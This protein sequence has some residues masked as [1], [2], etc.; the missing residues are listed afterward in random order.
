[1]TPAKTKDSSRLVAIT[2]DEASIGRSNPDVEHERATAIYDLLEENSFAPVGHAGGPYSLNIGLQDN[3]LVLDI[4][5]PDG[6]PLVAHIL[7][8]TPFKRIVKDYYMICD[9]YYAAIRTAT[10][11]RIEAIDMGRRGLHDEGSRILQDAIKR[12]VKVD[13]DTARRLFTLICV[14]HWKG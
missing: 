4:R 7:S 13:F 6:K 14:L 3:R 8:L 10:P 1:M 12:K 2:L 9:S 11:D 5:N